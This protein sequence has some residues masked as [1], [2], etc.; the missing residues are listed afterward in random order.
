MLEDLGS[1]YSW[2]FEGL[3][4]EWCGVAR[5]KWLS[6]HSYL[7]YSSMEREELLWM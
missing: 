1:G 3:G 2:M 4:V 5:L 7:L 6:L